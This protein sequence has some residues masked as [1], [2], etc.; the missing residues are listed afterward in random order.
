MAISS[1]FSTKIA[2][3]MDVLA[4][5]AVAEITKLVDEGTVVL[6]LELCRRESE[7]EAL[8]RSLQLTEFELCK[9]KDTSGPDTREH[10]VLGIQVKSPKAHQKDSKADTLCFENEKIDHIRESGYSENE[11]GRSGGLVKVE[12]VD[13][14]EARGTTQ[15]LCLT[16]HGNFEIEDREGQFWPA[17]CGDGSIE[18]DHPIEL[19][20]PMLSSQADLYGNPNITESSSFSSPDTRVLHDSFNSVPVKTE[21]ETPTVH[22]TSALTQSIQTEQYLDTLHSLINHGQMQQAGPSQ[23]QRAPET[24]SV[25]HY[26][27]QSHDHALNRNKFKTKRP[28][29]VWRSV[30]NQKVFICSVCGKGFSRFSQL[31]VHQFS[32]GGVKPY[33]CLEC[34]K[35]F[36]Q[37]TRLKTHQSVHTGERPFSCKIC[38]KMFSRQDNCLRHE[39]F[40]SGLKPY[41]CLQCGKTFT[42]L[43]NLKIHQQIHTS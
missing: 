23:I 25:P 6:R 3:I 21:L 41:T 14:H 37:K 38:G 43:S 28:I 42:V 36:T 2:A 34:G 17:V 27:A 4:K 32:H 22:K 11:S 12:P 18:P 30:T 5:A 7:I 33:R 31:E 16:H 9:A 10:P 20:L 13:K 26:V 29:N 15:D 24:T 35:S 1:S 40:H 39:R 8:K 19:C